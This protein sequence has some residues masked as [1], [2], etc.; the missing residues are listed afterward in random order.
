MALIWVGL[1]IMV[2]LFTLEWHKIPLVKYY[3]A[4]TRN[5]GNGDS[6]LLEAR[7]YLTNSLCIKSIRGNETL[8]FHLLLLWPYMK[9]TLLVTNCVPEKFV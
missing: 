4:Q 1:L 9:M 8:T 6:S 2:L 7:I 3:A 5:L